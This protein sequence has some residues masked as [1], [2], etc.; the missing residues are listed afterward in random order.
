MINQRIANVLA[1]LASR[2]YQDKYILHGTASHYVLANELLEDVFS[3][4]DLIRQQPNNFS[5]LS[6]NEISTIAQTL[7]IIKDSA[8]K[9]PEQNDNRS[10]SWQNP[11]W[12]NITDRANICLSQLEIDL[13]QWE[14]ENL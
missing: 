6:Q 11:I 5:A 10:L 8:A 4:S 2:A 1:P 12:Q 3:L 13:T 14:Q 9:L 7:E